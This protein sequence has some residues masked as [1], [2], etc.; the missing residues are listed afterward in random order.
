MSQENGKG[1]LIAI[2]RTKKGRRFEVREAF[3]GEH[4]A[5]LCFSPDE[6]HIC[7]FFHINCSEPIDDS[8]IPPCTRNKVYFLEVQK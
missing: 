1:K 7:A 6:E 8:F 3:V 2:I 4:G 5:G